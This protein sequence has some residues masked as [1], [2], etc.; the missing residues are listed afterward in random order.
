[1]HPGAGEDDSGEKSCRRSQ[2]LPISPRLR[3]GSPVSVALSGNAHPPLFSL[4]NRKVENIIL[5]PLL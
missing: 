1:C 4:K 2:Y 5:A 3:D